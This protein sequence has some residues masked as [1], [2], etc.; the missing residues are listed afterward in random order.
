MASELQNACLLLVPQMHLPD[1]SHPKRRGPL[2]PQGCCGMQST[3]VVPRAPTWVS[4]S[5]LSMQFLTKSD[6]R[7]YV[8]TM[9][10]KGQTQQTNSVRHAPRRHRQ[11]A[12]PPLRLHLLEIESQGMEVSSNPRRTD[13]IGI[14]RGLR[15]QFALSSV[16]VFSQSG[17]HMKRLLLHLHATLFMRWMILGRTR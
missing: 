11:A 3:S 5:L 7:T 15:A 10:S 2:V 13:I 1:Y 6:S 17:L 4:W 16:A 9:F 8:R 14:N 12:S